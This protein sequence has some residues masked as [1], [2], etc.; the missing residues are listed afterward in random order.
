MHRKLVSLLALCAIVLAACSG[1]PGSTPVPTDPKAILSGSATSLQGLKSLH[2]KVAVAGSV[3][4]GDLTGGLTGG[5]TSSA[6]PSTAPQMIDLSGTTIEGD[7]DVAGG[8]GQVAVSVPALLAFSANLIS[9]GGVTYVKTS[10]GDS[11]YA[12]LDLSSLASGLPIPSLPALGSP[13]PSAAADMTAAIQAELA[14]LPAPTQ[15]PDET[16]NGQ[17]CFHVQEVVPSSAIPDSSDVL[18]GA[19]GTLTVDLWSQKSDL[20]PSRLVIVIDAG[21]SGKLTLT[22]DLTN[23]DAA[24]TISPPPPDQISDQ[25]FS[26]PGL[27]P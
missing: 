17:D 12:K 23:Y 26:I 10:L 18:N 9:V 1:G 11:K 15:L 5:D 27:T 16:V 24:V 4:A 2:F 21:T 8:N 13:D 19:S 6:A 25:P 7:L 22:V 3:N 20:R 14:K